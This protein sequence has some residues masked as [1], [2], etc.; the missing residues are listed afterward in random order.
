VPQLR[1][2]ILDRAGEPLEQTPKLKM[3]NK[4]ILDDFPFDVNPASGKRNPFDIASEE[5]ET[6]LKS[7]KYGGR[8]MSAD[9]ALQDRLTSRDA[10]W[11]QRGLHEF[12]EHHPLMEGATFRQFWLDRGF[13]HEEVKKITVEIPTAVHRWISDAP[14]GKTPFWDEQLFR[15]IDKMETLYKRLL[16]KD[17]VLDV[18]GRLLNELESWSTK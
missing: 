1:L 4:P 15:E 3:G 11:L 6:L 12:E 8:R 16:T 17:E 9:E 7:G 18:V 14:P 13:S 2:D 5:S 10:Q